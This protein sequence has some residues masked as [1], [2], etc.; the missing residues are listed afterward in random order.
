MK[1]VLTTFTALSFGSI[2]FRIAHFLGWS[3]FQE[4]LFILA[5]ALLAAAFVCAPLWA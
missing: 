2:G 5:A 1:Y 3:Q 4:R